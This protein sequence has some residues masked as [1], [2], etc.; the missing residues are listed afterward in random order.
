M[1]EI[2]KAATKEKAASEACAQL[3]RLFDET[4]RPLLFLSS[5]GSALGLLDGLIPPTNANH[6]TLSVLDDRYTPDPAGS[7]RMQFLERPAVKK[8]ITNGA[9]LLPVSVDL[10]Q[11]LG[12]NAQLWGEAVISWKS[13]HPTG[14]IVATI[15]IGPDKHTYGVLPFPD[16]STFEQTFGNGQPYVG[17][18]ALV[19]TAYPD[20]ITPNPLAHPFIDIG[21]IYAV[22][23]EKRNAIKAVI[24]GTGSVWNTPALLLRNLPSAMLYTVG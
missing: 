21:I 18:H 14:Q 2:H 7:N 22:G 6:M 10:N 23:A 16:Q 19:A 15:G 8:L 12:I 9:G 13:T 1:I 20:R 4:R 17:Y 24:E 5:G 11:S 3:Q